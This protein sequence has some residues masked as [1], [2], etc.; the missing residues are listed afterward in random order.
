MK[1]DKLFAGFNISAMG[2]TAQRK[3]MNAIANNM[4]N[5]ETTKTEDGQPYRRKIVVVKGTSDE[6]FSSALNTMTMKLATT[7]EGHISDAADGSPVQ[8][9]ASG[10]VQST[11]EVDSSPFKM[12]YDPGHPDADK[13]GY[14]K[15]PNVNVVTEMVDMI[16]ATR[17]Y[18]ANVTAIDGAKT[19][20]KDALEI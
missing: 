13:D 15:M 1:L 3:R 18:E 19:M 10:S 16:S 7:N 14:V 17:S 6:S 9:G 4:A 12:V 11:E 5:A 8:G 2:L 20:A